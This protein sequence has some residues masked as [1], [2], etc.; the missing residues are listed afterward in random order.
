VEGITAPTREGQRGAAR[1]GRKEGEEK[2]AQTRKEGEG[3]NK[4]SFCGG[5]SERGV[6]KFKGQRR[7]ELWERVPSPTREGGRTPPT[8]RKKEATPSDIKERGAQGSK[9][10]RWG[11]PCLDG[12][13]P[14]TS[15][16]KR[17]EKPVKCPKQGVPPLGGEAV[18]LK[19]TK[20]E[21]H[22]ERKNHLKK[23]P[24]SLCK[25]EGEGEIHPA[26]RYEGQSMGRGS[27]PKRGIISLRGG[28]ALTCCF[29]CRKKETKKKGRGLI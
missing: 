29:S 24:S 27:N 13:A 15:C 9:Q 23:N 20:R 11:R 1:T 16:E 6:G 28:K 22:R 7:L 2:G 26:Q 14:E 18:S 25:K 3:R 5:A 12:G 4:T 17:G 21:A 19:R 8:K 10:R